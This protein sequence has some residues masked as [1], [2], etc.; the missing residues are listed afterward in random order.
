[1]SARKSF[2]DLLKAG[3]DKDKQRINLRLAAPA[4]QSISKPAVAP[5]SDFN[6]RANSLERDA[7]PKGLFPGASKA[8]YDALYLRTLGAINPTN[9]I[10]A[11]RKQI[12]SWSGVKNIKTINAHLKKLED[13]GF[14]KRSS[15]NGEPSGNYFEIYL[16]NQPNSVEKNVKI[17]PD[18]TQ[19]R[20]RPDPDQT[21]TENWSGS[22]L[23]NLVENKGTYGFSF[24]KTLKTKNDDEPAALL[25]S[26]N[27]LFFESDLGLGV[28]SSFKAVEVL[29]SDAG[30]IEE[31]IN[32]ISKKLVGKELKN[33]DNE[34]LKELSEIL[35][36]ELEIAAAR[37]NSISNV[38]AFLTEHL[39]RRLYGK[40]NLQ[41]ANKTSVAKS[42]GKSPTNVRIAD[43]DQSVVENYQAEPLTEQAKE[44]VLKTMVEYIGR[45]QSEFV[46]SL[47]NTYTADD[48][49]W[50]S[51]NLSGKATE[52][53]SKDGKTK[54]R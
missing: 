28:G 24:L 9:M 32:K 36:M 16:P 31:A 52:N 23:G 4:A 21:Q 22:G 5:E 8:I 44:T 19:T 40:S 48:W 10:Q 12:I 47:E 51:E 11:T 49:K 29:L 26:D 27:N 34:K 43:S 53:H 13:R 25:E 15:F 35:V 37:T 14:I 17:D 1:M 41:N 6:R 33:T 7:L 2:A 3:A 46:M 39:R 18:Q 20:P 30:I 38:P 42:S 50:L 45:G 54:T